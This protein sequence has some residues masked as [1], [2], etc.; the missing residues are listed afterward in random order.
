MLAVVAATGCRVGFDLLPGSGADDDAGPQVDADPLAPDA[1]PLAPDAKPA[2]DAAQA[3]GTEAQSG[4]KSPDGASDLI[5]I[6]PVLLA[7]SFVTCSRRSPSSLPSLH[8]ARC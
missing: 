8:L 2:P 5:P 6:D 4:K 1:D 7:E 3:M